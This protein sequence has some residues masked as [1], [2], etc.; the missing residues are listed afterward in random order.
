MLGEGFLR[1]ELRTIIQGIAI[2][3]VYILKYT[4]SNCVSKSYPE[5]GREKEDEEMD[6]GVSSSPFCSFS[7]KE[8]SRGHKIKKLLLK[9][10]NSG[11]NWSV[12]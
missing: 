8:V 4:Q 1:I 3:W 5:W 6:A 12:S 10:G 11:E 2:S 9:K 7:C